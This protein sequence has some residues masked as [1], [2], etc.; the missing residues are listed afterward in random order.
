MIQLKHIEKKQSGEV[1]LAGLSLELEG[2]GVFGLLDSSGR[3]KKNIIDILSGV[4][5]SFGGELILDEETYSAKSREKDIVRLKKQIGYLPETPVFYGDMT[6]IETL[7]LVGETKGINAES[8]YRQIK[9]ALELTGTYSIRDILCSKLSASQKRRVAFATALLGNPKLIIIDEPY[10]N[11]SEREC[12]EIKAIIDM[13]G[14]VKPVVI[15]TVSEDAI[16]SLCKTVFVIRDGKVAFEGDIE[17]LLQNVSTTRLLDVRMV[18]K[19]ERGSDALETVFNGVDY[20]LFWEL[21][22]LSDAGEM[23]IRIETQVTEDVDLL[24]KK[25]LTDNGYIVLSLEAARRKL[26]LTEKAEV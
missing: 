7:D 20:V 25:L 10:A 14:K 23:S 3:C 17:E 4:D 15:A 1:I 12:D 2:N 19:E 16:I 13:I 11:F 18:S 6:V 24:I 21:L 9:E 8:R 5:A 26:K 22:N